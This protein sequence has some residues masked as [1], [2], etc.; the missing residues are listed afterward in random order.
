MKARNDIGKVG[1]KKGNFQNEGIV[2]RILRARIA[3]KYRKKAHK[4]FY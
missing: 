3:R 1:S 4:H 2:R